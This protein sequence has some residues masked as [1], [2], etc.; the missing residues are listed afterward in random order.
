[1]RTAFKT[2][3]DRARSIPEWVPGVLGFNLFSKYLRLKVK[4]GLT[5]EG[6]IPS[7]AV[8]LHTVLS[9]QFQDAVLTPHIER[10]PRSF[11]F[12][13]HMIMCNAQL[14]VQPDEG[15]SQLAAGRFIE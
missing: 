10:Q 1:M 5:E 6:L 13:L 7:S 12:A 11:C 15:S 8:G 3:G 4:Y 9:T 2:E 14:Y